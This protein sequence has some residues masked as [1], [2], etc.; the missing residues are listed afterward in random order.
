VRVTKRGA[1]LRASSKGGV[2][3]AYETKS[4]TA[5]FALEGSA[6][7]RSRNR[8]LA[9]LP[10]DALFCLRPYLKPVSLPRARVLCEADEPLEHAYF[11]EVGP[12]ALVT[13]FENGTTAEMATVGREEDGLV[14]DLKPTCAKPPANA[15]ASAIRQRAGAGLELADEM[16]SMRCQDL[17]RG[18]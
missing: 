5:A 18:S 12:G 9:A 1:P 8:L 4:N 14:V 7:F 13:V 16:V 11:V 15:S 10:H 3:C 2:G 6:S 17:P